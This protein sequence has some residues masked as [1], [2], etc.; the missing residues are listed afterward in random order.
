MKGQIGKVVFIKTVRQPLPKA[1]QVWI[2]NNCSTYL[3]DIYGCCGME[4]EDLLPEVVQQHV[5]Q[6]GGLFSSASEFHLETILP[7]AFEVN[8]NEVFDAN[9]C[10]Y[11]S[12]ELHIKKV[13]CQGI[14]KV[15]IEKAGQMAKFKAKR[16]REEQ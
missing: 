8:S 3:L 14:G 10:I 13:H 4:A 7:Y 11:T 1:T 15:N 5:K 16:L 6:N 12:S 2:D 9:V